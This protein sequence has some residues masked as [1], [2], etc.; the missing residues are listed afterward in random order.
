MTP[1][2]VQAVA[3][4]QDRRH[5][6]QPAAEDVGASDHRLAAERVEETAEHE[7]PEQVADGEH[8][9]VVRNV[10]ARHLEVRAEE[11][12]E[13]EQDRVVEERL[14]DEQTE[15]EH[16][17]ARV[18]RQDRLDRQRQRNRFALAHGHLPFRLGQILAGRRAHLV[19]DVGH[20]LLGLLLA[21]VDEQPPRALRDTPAHDQDPETEDRA[22]AEAQPPAD[23][24]GEDAG[25][26]REHREERAGGRP[27]PVAAVDRDVDASAF[28]RGDQL[29]DRRVDRAVLAANAEPGEEAA[30]V[31]PQ[32]REREGRERRRQQIDAERDHEQ[33]LAAEA[34]GELAEEERADARAGDVQRSRESGHVR[35]GDPD[36]GTLLAKATRDATDDRHF[37]AVEN[38]HGPEADH[39]FP[40]PA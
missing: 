12:A 30:H 21:A 32:G 19:L 28:L 31:E 3:L 16:G 6:E 29:V 14:A 20:D 9:E 10:A 8:D 24:D 13:A 34:V 39:H 15:P 4:E 17:P 25:V 26:E 11:V 38:P 33:L 37:K 35:G 36:A 2:G 7:R 5:D 1:S 40:M 27:A 22:E 23:V 18:H